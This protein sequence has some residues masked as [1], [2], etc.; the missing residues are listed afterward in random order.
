MWFDVLLSTG[1]GVVS[2]ARAKEFQDQHV[3]FRPETTSSMMN[4]NILGTGFVR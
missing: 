2:Q 4:M 1:V 3:S